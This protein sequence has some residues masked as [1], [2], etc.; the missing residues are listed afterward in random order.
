MCT[1]P[2]TNVPTAANCEHKTTT[3]PA[4]PPLA[5]SPPQG[6]SIK[7]TTLQ[8]G[9]FGIR[10][11][12]A[13][14]LTAAQLTSAQAAVKRKI[15]PVKG[16]ELF[17]RVF[18]DVPVCVKGNETRMGKG[19]GTFEYWACRV[20]AGRVI[21]E[22][23]GGNIREE[24]ARQALKLAQVKMPVATEFI[25]A[26]APP[27]LGDIASHELGQAKQ[28]LKTVKVQPPTT[29]LAQ[30]VAAREATAAAAAAAATP[31]SAPSA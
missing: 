24:I 11:M 14:R 9:G 21:F 28:G 13:V 18:P 26:K 1:R 3:T 25:N 27:R 22:V 5:N 30:A 19:K 8:F 10:L 16:A 2:C 20:P 17:M 31:V 6:G 7:G 12:S 4:Q 29:P 23:A 15:K